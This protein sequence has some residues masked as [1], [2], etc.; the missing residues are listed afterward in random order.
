MATHPLFEGAGGSEGEAGQGPA[1]PPR[2]MERSRDGER[3]TQQGGSRTE[4]LRGNNRDT[5]RRR[6]RSTNLEKEAE[7]E[8][9][10]SQSH[11]RDN[12]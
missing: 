7:A 10:N 4:K 6:Q 8:R 3:H 11:G 12:Q 5:Q 9:S 2:A 1:K